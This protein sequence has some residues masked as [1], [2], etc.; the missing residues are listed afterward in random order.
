MTANPGMPAGASIRRRRR[1]EAGMSLVET[2]LS[3]VVLAVACLTA[4][5]VLVSSMELDAVNH[6]T[7]VAFDA[8]RARMEMVRAQRFN[9]VIAAFNLDPA[10]DPQGAGTAPGPTFAVT[11]LP[12]IAAGAAPHGT[13]ILPVDS[14]GTVRENLSIPALGLPRD[15]NGDTRVDSDD[16]TADAILIPVLVRVRWNGSTGSRETVLST[17]L[18]P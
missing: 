10:D 2:A 18:R 16:H 4:L 6:E 12:S 5:S 11:D 7:K 1:A 14:A 3:M 8:A 15:L 9:E 13:V 17:V